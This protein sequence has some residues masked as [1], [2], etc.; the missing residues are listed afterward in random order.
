MDNV[1]NFYVE[2][3]PHEIPQFASSEL[4]SQNG[5]LSKQLFNLCSVQYIEIRHCSS[6]PWNRNVYTWLTLLQ[7]LSKLSFVVLGAS[8]HGGSAT[9]HKR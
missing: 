1:F 5:V 4:G 9:R 2:H 6:E 8:E 3:F 7:K